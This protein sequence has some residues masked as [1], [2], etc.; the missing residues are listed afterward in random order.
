MAETPILEGR[1]AIVT[2]ASRGIGAEIARAMAL[3]GAAVVVAARDE[4]ALTRVVAEIER[5]GGRALVAPADVSDPD[6][7]KRLIATTVDELGGLDVAVN[8]AAGGGHGPTP[9]AEVSPDQFHSALAISLESVFLS[10]KFEIPAMLASG[11]GAIVNMAS[12]AGLEAVGGLAGYVAAKHGVIGLTKVAALDYAAQGV[13]V[14]AIA[15]GPILTERLEAAGEDAQR[16]AGQAMPMRR[17][18]R[19]IEVASAAVWLCSDQ[20][21]F[22]TGATLNI[23]GGKLAGTPPFSRSGS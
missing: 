11:G 18:G 4:D 23:D 8:N 2:G 10:L 3:A 20:A 17:I 6:A 22:V 19:P 15:P 5:E 9:L 7:V 14:N 12:S 1:R 13:R 16:T 21:S